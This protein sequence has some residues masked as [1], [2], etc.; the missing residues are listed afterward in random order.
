MSVTVTITL[1]SEGFIKPCHVPNA[2]MSQVTKQI[3]KPYQLLQQAD[4]RNHAQ[5]TETSTSSLIRNR[6]F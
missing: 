4:S 1:L 2:H 3:H 6:T 5:I